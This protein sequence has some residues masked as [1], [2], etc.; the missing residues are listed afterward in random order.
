[1]FTQFIFKFKC[2]FLPRNWQDN[3]V[4]T[5]ISMQ[6]MKP[7]LSW[8][9]CVHE[10]N[11]ELGIAKSD[12]HIAE[13]KLRAHFVPR[14][15]P[16]LKTSYD[17]NNTHL[18]LNKIAE[19]DTWIERVHLLDVKLEN[20]H[21]KWLKLTIS[22]GQANAKSRGVLRNSNFINSGASET[23]SNNSMRNGPAPI[24]RLTQTFSLQESSNGLAL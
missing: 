6:G 13:D 15:S 5:Q 8:T 7:F 21:A 11:T 24:Q 14:L 23:G 19:L 16:V 1:M 18:D 9:E 12:Y 22:T 3:L 17:A 20:K 2:K 10:A 4:S